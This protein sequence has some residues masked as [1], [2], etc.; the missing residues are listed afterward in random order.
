MPVVTINGGPTRSTGDTSPWTDGTTAE[1]AGTT[2]HLSIGGQHLTATVQLGG[3][4]GVSAAA[5]PDGTYQ[6]VARITDAAQ[7]TGTA[8]RPSPSTAPAGLW[9]PTPATDRTRPCACSAEASRVS[10]GTA[11]ASGSPSG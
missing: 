10:A 9:T 8:T 4:W 3:A 11:P 6:V 5:L 1:P 2:V 7:N